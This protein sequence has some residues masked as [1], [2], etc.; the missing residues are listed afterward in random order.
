MPNSYSATLAADVSPFIELAP[1]DKLRQ[2]LH[3]LVDTLGSM[4]DGGASSMD[5]ARQIAATTQDLATQALHAA[6]NLHGCAVGHIAVR[7]LQETTDALG[8]PA[9]DRPHPKPEG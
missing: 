9:Q 8:I 3:T 7:L 6:I 2:A 4:L 5:Y 1:E